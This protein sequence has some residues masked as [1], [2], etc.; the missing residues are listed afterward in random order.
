MNNRT[1]AASSISGSIDPK[2]VDG[3]QALRTGLKLARASQLTMLRLQLALYNSNRRTAMQALDNLLAVDAE[4]EGLTA[5]LDNFPPHQG[6]DSALPGFIKLQRAAIAAEKHVLTGGDGRS[7]AKAIAN[8]AAVH[9]AGE[10]DLPAQ[11]LLSAD[12]VEG[13]DRAGNRHWMHVLAIAIV[14]TFIGFGLI[15]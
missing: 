15:A 13:D 7:D 5:R 3:M 1:S 8:A 12:E 2:V 4:M 6:D 9:W 10:A 14:V 11:P